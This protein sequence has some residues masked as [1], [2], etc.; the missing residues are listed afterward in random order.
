MWFDARAALARIEGGA[1]PA[2]EALDR[3]N[4][5][6]PALQSANLNAPSAPV[7]FARFAGFATPRRSAP[8]FP[9][10]GQGVVQMTEAA[11]A[12]AAALPSKPPTCALCG[13][14][15][16]QVSLTDTKRRTLHVACWRAEQGG[17]ATENPKC[18]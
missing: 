9:A 4:S 18:R 8:A 14:A 11:K 2:P 3:P 13:A 6:P 10:T 7:Q 16:W 5:Q 12:R 1:C 15:D 17:D